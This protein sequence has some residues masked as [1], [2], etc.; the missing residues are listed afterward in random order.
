MAEEILSYKCNC[1][2][3]LKKSH[4]QV[5]FFG[6]DFGIR[7]CEVCTKCGSEYL[8]DEVLDEVE[9][10]VKKKKLFGIEKEVEITK[11]GNSLVI[12]LPPQIAKFLEARYKDRVRIYPT[13]KSKILMGIQPSS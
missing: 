9:Q 8:S 2:G 10:E 12:R 7:E 6:I 11:S 5:E 13:G 3:I 1:G 4:T